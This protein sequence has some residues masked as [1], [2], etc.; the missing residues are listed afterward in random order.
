M[1]DCIHL[2]DYSN[3]HQRAF[4]ALNLEWLDVYNL[5]ESHDLHM[6]DDPDGTIIKR[7]G[8]IYLAQCGVRMVGS[9]ALLKDQEDVYELAK[10]T[11]ATDFRGRGISKLL[12]E[13]CIG[14]ARQ[15]KAAKITLF[16]NHQ[17]KVA[18]GLYEQY[19]FK[20]IPVVGSPFATADVKME[21][22]L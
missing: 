1:E 22:I 8:F 21:L 11:V 13:K 20:H 5:T 12:L 18:I 7:G 6:L 16:S 9:A 17:L 3:E 4:K 19:G 10:M 2:I 15:L 14:K